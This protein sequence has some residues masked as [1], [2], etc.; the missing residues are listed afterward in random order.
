MIPLFP[1]WLLNLEGHVF[2]AQIAFFGESTIPGT[3]QQA[4]NHSHNEQHELQEH[5][6]PSPGPKPTILYNFNQKKFHFLAL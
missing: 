2:G 4:V 3:H 6:T 5:K 1:V